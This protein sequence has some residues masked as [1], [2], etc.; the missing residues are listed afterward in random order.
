MNFYY[1]L[2]LFLLICI[3]LRILLIWWASESDDDEFQYTAIGV[4]T[5]MIGLGFLVQYIRNKNRGGF[6]EKVYWSRPLHSFLYILFSLLWFFK[7]PFSYIVL[8]VDVV[9]GF[10][11]FVVHY[12]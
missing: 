4:I 6:G 2:L 8:I 12:N 3:P 7:V 9:I 1:R 5:L 11:T 10:G